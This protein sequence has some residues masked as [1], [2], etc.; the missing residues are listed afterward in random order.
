MIAPESIIRAAGVEGRD[1]G[2]PGST[3]KKRCDGEEWEL[4]IDTTGQR[5][6]DKE[7]G[8]LTLN[9]HQGPEVGNLDHYSLELGF[10]LSQ[11]ELGETSPDWLQHG[12][13][14]ENVEVGET[15]SEAVAAV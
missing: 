13:W 15:H 2:S 12:K 4:Q 8:E 9:A 3:G 7:W 10:L 5:V 1:N 11:G 6:G 14:T